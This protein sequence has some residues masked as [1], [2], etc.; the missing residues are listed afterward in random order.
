MRLI[1]HDK[2]T[3]THYAYSFSL[4]TCEWILSINWNE[5]GLS[6]NCQVG[7]TWRQRGIENFIGGFS[8][9]VLSQKII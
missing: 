1:E 4:S 2:I 9:F 5:I 8:T 7:I 3:I 6:A